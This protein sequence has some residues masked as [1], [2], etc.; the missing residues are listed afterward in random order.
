[1][2][3]VKFL[4]IFKRI[5]SIFFDILNNSSPNATFDHPI[6]E[7]YVKKFLLLIDAV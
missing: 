5:R 7:Y 2:Y 1:M 6:I 4:L 3:C